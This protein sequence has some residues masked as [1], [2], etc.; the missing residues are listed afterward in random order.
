MAVSAY[1][2]ICIRVAV[3]NTLQTSFP[4]SMKKDSPKATISIE[5]THKTCSRVFKISKNITT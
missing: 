2:Q 1:I 4:M 3:D 5:K